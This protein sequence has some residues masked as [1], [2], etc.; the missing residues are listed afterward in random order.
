[1]TPD[2]PDQ[3]L[4]RI[5]T[6][7]SVV[8]KAHQGP[9]DAVAAAQ[10]QLIER[11]GGAIRRYLGGALRDPDA[12]DELFQEFAL[13]FVRGDFRRA[14]PARGRFRDF[15]KTSLFHLIVD[16]QKRRRVRLA[17]LPSDTPDP[18]APSVDPCDDRTFVQSWRDELLARAW[19]ALA[20]IERSTAQPYY[21][22][23][24]FRAE[25]PDTRSPD[26][27]AEL[28][29]RLDRPLTADGVRQILHRARERF[30][31]LLLDEVTQSLQDPDADAL[32]QEL[33]DLDLL[34]YCRETLNRR[35]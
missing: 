1:M 11:Y 18:A 24:R 14:D 15:L 22:V 7:W 34:S 8:C 9:Q 20:Q 35:R 3:H 29:R 5:M 2:D 27:A 17:N 13:R 10:R 33:I 28:G 31:D 21:A 19:D 4:S 16:H 25:H 6:L 30:A 12:A 32:E 26:M 23:L